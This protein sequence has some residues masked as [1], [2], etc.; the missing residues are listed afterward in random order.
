MMNSQGGRGGSLL[1]KTLQDVGVSGLGA[2]QGM[3]SNLK[4]INAAKKTLQA[5]TIESTKAD[6]ARRDALIGQAGGMYQSEV[7]KKIGLAQVASNRAL[8]EQIANNKLYEDAEKHRLTT[9]ASMAKTNL[10]DATKN[11]KYSD[12]PAVAEQQALKDATDAY[13][14]TLTQKTRDL[15]GIQAPTAAPAPLAPAANNAAPN[16]GQVLVV[17]PAMDGKPAQTFY[18][19]NQAAA[20]AANAKIKQ[21]VEA[22][23]NANYV[24]PTIM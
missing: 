1:N 8:Q 6:Q 13:D 22:Q 12:N 23:K 7:N 18:A 3:T 4:D 24:A 16:A 21:M 15:L 17:V 11:F 5:G 20:D 2:V 10:S 19:P 9:I 14:R